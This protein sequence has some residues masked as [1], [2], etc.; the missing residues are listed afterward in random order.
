M[1]QHLDPWQILYYP[2]E[3]LQ[4]PLWKLHP[5]DGGGR[6]EGRKRERFTFMGSTYRM[7]YCWPRD[8][9]YLFLFTYSNYVHSSPCFKI[10]FCIIYTN[11]LIAIRLI[12][13]VK[14]SGISKLV[15]VNFLKQEESIYQNASLQVEASTQLKLHQTLNSTSFG[16]AQ[17]R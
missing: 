14:C 12:K 9:L 5:L 3:E 10:F 4:Q 16:A 17:R 8:K 2:G 1:N 6:G 11:Q 7:K 13:I 15:L